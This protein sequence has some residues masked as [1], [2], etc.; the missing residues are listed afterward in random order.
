M[1]DAADGF[2]GVGELPGE[3]TDARDPR[4]NLLYADLSGLGP[5]YT[6]AGG[7]ETLADDTRLLDVGL[8]HLAGRGT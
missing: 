8:F 6:Q 4:V 2:L 3:G 7:D 1:D 5:V